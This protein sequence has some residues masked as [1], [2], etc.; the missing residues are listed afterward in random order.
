[1]RCPIQKG[2]SKIFSPKNMIYQL[3]LANLQIVIKG[4]SVS[5]DTMIDDHA[6]SLSTVM[7]QASG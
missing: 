7:P 1:M 3:K 4:I 2:G 6:I 5:V